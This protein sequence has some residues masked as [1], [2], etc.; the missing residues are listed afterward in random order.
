M[1]K[2]KEFKMAHV[3]MIRFSQDRDSLT[4]RSLR[5]KFMS[6]SATDAVTT[7]AMVEIASTC[8]YT[9]F[10]ISDAFVQIVV[11]AAKAGTAGTVMILAVRKAE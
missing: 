11:S 2:P 7:A 1:M 4:L 10:M 9:S 6:S 8:V 3:M 5:E